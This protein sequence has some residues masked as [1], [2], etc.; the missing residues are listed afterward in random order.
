M[1]LGVFGA[2]NGHRLHQT[3]GDSKSYQFLLQ[4]L[5]VAIQR[6]NVLETLSSWFHDFSSVT[7]CVLSLYEVVLL[8]A[9]MC[10]LESS[11]QEK[12]RIKGSRRQKRH[13]HPNC[14]FS[15]LTASLVTS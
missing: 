13:L 7:D 4:S 3:T 8:L 11:S 12:K 15:G 10:T 14:P 6:G 1:S 5:S 2:A 9:R